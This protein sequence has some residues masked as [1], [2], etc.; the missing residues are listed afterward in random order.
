MRVRTKSP[1]ETQRLAKKLADKIG[2]SKPQSHA[3]V[4]A[5]EGEL[6]AGKTTFVKGFAHALG[7]KSRITSP[8]FLLMRKFE[9]RNPKF[10]KKSKFQIL[11]SKF[12]NLIHID[13][14]RLRDHRDLA[15]LGIKEILAE[16]TNIV[17][18]EWADRVKK[19]LPRKYIQVHI[20]HIARDV[21]QIKIR[22]TKHEIR[23]NIE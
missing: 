22:S 17:L 10:E 6:G 9:I 8:T 4:I 7:I 21:R 13:A 19:I 3:V 14:Y 15:P 12:C 11:N 2:G 23:N 20:D 16:P 1:K 18:I 5:L